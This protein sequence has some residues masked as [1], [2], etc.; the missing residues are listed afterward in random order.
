VQPRVA[1]WLSY[2]PHAALPICAWLFA[3]PLIRLNS[4]ANMATETHTGRLIFGDGQVDM[5]DGTVLAVSGSPTPCA[6][7]VARYA[8][9]GE[10]Q[11]VTVTGTTGT[12]DNG[13][14]LFVTSIQWATTSDVVSMAA[15]ESLA[16]AIPAAEPESAPPPQKARKKSARSRSKK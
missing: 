4:L 8:K 14:V 16:G 7:A 15:P 6:T 5:E 13:P 3:K 12:V 10:T 2:V 9:W 11:P 1:R